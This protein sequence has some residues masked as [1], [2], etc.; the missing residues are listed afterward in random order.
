MAEEPIEEEA[1]RVFDALDAAEAMADPLARA[2]VIGRLLKD[3]AERNKRFTEY[4][5]QVVMELRAQVPP[6]PYRKI[7]SEL[8]VSLGTV[9]DIERGAAKWSSRPKP[10]A[11]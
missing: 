1:Q 11:E 3:Q 8:G 6:V 4:R 10:A 2:R 9:Q 7:A 5:R